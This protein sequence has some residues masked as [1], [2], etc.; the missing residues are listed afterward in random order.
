M[1][2]EYAFL[3]LKYD[4]P[5]RDIKAKPLFFDSK[6]MKLIEVTEGYKYTYYPSLW[7][8]DSSDKHKYDIVK[9]VT[10]D[11]VYVWNKKFVYTIRIYPRGEYV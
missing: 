8:R 2:T 11:G 7:L 6:S 4:T 5:L 9:R 10:C 3:K 1:K